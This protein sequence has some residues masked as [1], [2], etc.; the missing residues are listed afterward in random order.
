MYAKR[1]GTKSEK[2]LTKKSDTKN[3]DIKSLNN[4]YTVPP[5]HKTKRRAQRNRYAKPARRE[6]I[7]NVRNK[8]AKKLW[9]RQE[10]ININNNFN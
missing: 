8:V 5:M 6:I 1:V 9:R 3:K 4:V 7:K 2:V 10:E